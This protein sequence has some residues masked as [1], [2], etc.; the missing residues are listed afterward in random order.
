MTEIDEALVL[1]SQ[2]LKLAAP[3]NSA[4]SLFRRWFESNQPFILDGRALLDDKRDLV[5]IDPATHNDLL[6]KAIQAMCGWLF[7][8]SA[9]K[10]AGIVNAQH[11]PGE[12]KHPRSL[13]SNLLLQ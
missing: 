9:W 10:H 7:K 1:Q 8:V 12:A 11:R 5:T 2:V 13:G 6:T 4:L 3:D